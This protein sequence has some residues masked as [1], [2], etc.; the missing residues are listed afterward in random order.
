MASERSAMTRVPIGSMK[1]RFSE[2]ATDHGGRERRQETADD[3]GGHHDAEHQ[4]GL[5]T[6]VRPVR[7]SG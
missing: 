3:G 1:S 2:P 6:A 5:A 4:Q 7:E